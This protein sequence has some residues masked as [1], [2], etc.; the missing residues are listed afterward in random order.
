[1]LWIRQKKNWNT[2]KLM[3]RGRHREREREKNKKSK[4][5]WKRNHKNENYNWDFTTTNLCT[6]YPNEVL[7]FLVLITI[8]AVLKLHILG[9]SD[10]Y[11]ATQRDLYIYQ[12]RCALFTKKQIRCNPNNKI[13]IK[14]CYTLCIPFSKIIKNAHMHITRR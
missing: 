1:M 4:P 8:N 9:W 11:E 10:F 2:I 14:K 3:R 6:L 7:E 12:I 5:Y 13:A